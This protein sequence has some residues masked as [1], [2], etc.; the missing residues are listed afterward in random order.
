LNHLLG[1]VVQG[2]R[3]NELGF[4]AELKKERVSTKEFHQIIIFN[5]DG[6]FK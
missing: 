6:F 4:G 5:Q 3:G 2:S 1:A